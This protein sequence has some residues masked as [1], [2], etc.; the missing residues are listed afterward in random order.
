MLNADVA[1]DV[2]REVVPPGMTLA[3]DEGFA[4]LYRIDR[5]R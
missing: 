2:R 3:A 1:P 4:R 5:Q